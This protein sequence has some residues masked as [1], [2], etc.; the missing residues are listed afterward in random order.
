MNYCTYKTTHI[1][2]F[3]Y[4]G[5]AKTNN[6]LDGSYKG[7][8]IR[9]KICQNIPGFEFNTWTTTILEYFDSENEAYKAEELLV[10]IAL[11]ADPY[12]MNMN[13][14]GLVGKYQNHSKLYKMINSEKK[15][16][17]RKIKADKAKASKLATVNTIKELKQQLKERK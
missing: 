6:V 14:G 12:C 11:L 4:Y 2:G 10:P 7:S 16:I 5:K 13:A 9:F 1:S 3:Y 17:A 8:G 15:A